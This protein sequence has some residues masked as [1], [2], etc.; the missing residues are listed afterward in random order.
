MIIRIFINNILVAGSPTDKLA[1][2]V[3]HSANDEDVMV[4]NYD[5]PAEKWNRYVTPLLAN[6]KPDSVSFRYVSGYT[7]HTA[8][9][10]ITE[11]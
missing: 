1:D 8:A 6:S 5:I 11:L 10:Y 3:T 4:C 7:T 2:V 9:V